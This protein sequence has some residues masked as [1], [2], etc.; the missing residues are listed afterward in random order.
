ML[1]T[2]EWPNEAAFDSIASRSDVRSFVALQQQCRTADEF[3]RRCLL[4]GYF[5]DTKLRVV[6]WSITKH[7]NSARALLDVLQSMIASRKDG[8]FV[9]DSKEIWTASLGEKALQ[10][11]TTAD[12]RSSLA[13]ELLNG[14]TTNIDSLLRLLSLARLLPSL[15]EAALPT[16]RQLLNNTT[17]EQQYA[18]ITKTTTTQQNIEQLAI[19]ITRLVDVIA[20]IVPQLVATLIDTCRSQTATTAL[21]E[22]SSSVLRYAVTTVV[23]FCFCLFA[24]FSKQN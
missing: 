3:R 19:A 7:R 14:Q 22:S 11:T 12:V 16:I 8:Q 10:Q 6:L 4:D 17:I 2:D 13:N 15:T 5:N 24:L 1:L 20:P 21:C 9:E 23:F 18:Q